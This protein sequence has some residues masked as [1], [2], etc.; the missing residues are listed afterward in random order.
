[1]HATPF[2]ASLAASAALMAPVVHAQTGTAPATLPAIEVSADT[3]AAQ[4]GVRPIGGALPQAQIAHQPTQSVSVVDRQEIDRLNT[5]STLDLLAR[6]PGVSVNRAG[7]IAGTIFLRGLNS[8]DM[9][10]PLFI[11]GDR[12][13]GRNTLQ[14]MLISPSEIERVEVIRGPASS[15]YGS[16]GLSGLVNIVTRRPKGNL[17]QPFTISGGEAGLTYQSN[18]NGLQGDIA[19]E[20]AGSGFDTRLYITRRH[21]NDYDSANGLVP[22]S[23]FD[24]EGAGLVVGFMPD[25]TQRI[26]ASVRYASAKEGAAGTVPVYPISISRRDPNQV[27]QARLAYTGSFANQ[28]FSRVEGSFYVNEFDTEATVHNQANPL[29]VVDTRSKVIGPMVFGGRAAGVIPW[30]QTETTIGTDFIRERRPGTESRSTT[31]VRNAVGAI[32]SVIDTPNGKTGPDQYQ[33]NLGAFINT[34]WNPSSAWT[35]TA[36][37]RFDYV[38]SDVGLSPLPSA[39]LLPAFRAAQDSSETATTGSLGVVFRPAQMLELVGSAGTSFRMPWTNEMF[40][41]GY[42]GTSYTIPNPGLKPERGV[43]VETGFRLKF[44]D[45][46]LAVTAFQSKFR[47]FLQNVTSTYQGLPATQRQNVGRATIKGLEAE[48]RWQLDRRV[49]VFGNATYLH[50]TDTTANTPLPSIA[51]F[52]GRV[53]VQYVG[54]AQAYAITG[55]WQWAKGKS[56]INA[57]Q[58]YPS[59]GYGAFNVFAELQ[60]NRLGLPQVGNTQL[61][62]GVTNLFDKA[63]RGAATSSNRSYALSDL[64]P[65][66]EPG[67]SVNL[68]LRTRF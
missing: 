53:G 10:S 37:G 60:L 20:G 54:P 6:T 12:F 52:G 61:V 31:T 63:Y 67:R 51:P 8:N 46:T 64:N 23:D 22:N 55:E 57:A 19:I 66:L 58:E 68:S 40:S 24:T 33:T 42:T 48:W 34:D 41:S 30:G 16:D 44:P 47:D 21:A 59:G 32:T 15:M 25:A 9:R 65:L 11:D 1:M 13:R 5:L 26:E 43:N 36:A 39:N 7:G 56:R 50:A 18:G 3:E 27:K 17:D 38:N 45:A 28:L 2:L 29:R 62:L 14:Y 4:T 49:N 35:V